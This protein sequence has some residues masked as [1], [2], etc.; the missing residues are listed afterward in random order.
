MAIPRTLYETEHTMFG[1]LVRE[2][3]ERHV[4]PN[5]EKWDIEGKVDRLLGL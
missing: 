4:R 5:V 1:E 3:V 2:F